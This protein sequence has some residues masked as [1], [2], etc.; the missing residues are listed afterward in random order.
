MR[1]FNLLSLA[2]VSSYIKKGLI[3]NDLIV[4][5]WKLFFALWIFAGLLLTIGFSEMVWAY[6]KGRQYD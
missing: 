6:G 1:R 2:S 5:N 3:M 4:N